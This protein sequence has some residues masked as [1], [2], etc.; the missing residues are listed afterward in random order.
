MCRAL[1]D[2]LAP[3]RPT[4]SVGPMAVPQ[5]ATFLR[6]YR[7]E[8]ELYAIEQAL[9]EWLWVE[10]QER[11][12]LADDEEADRAARVQGLRRA[13]DAAYRATPAA[14][15]FAALQR[16][17]QREQEHFAAEYRESLAE[18]ADPHP[19]VKQAQAHREVRE[20]VCGPATAPAARPAPEAPPPAPPA[21]PPPGARAGAGGAAGAAEGA[22]EDMQF[23]GMLMPLRAEADG[24]SM[25]A[26]A[27]SR[28]SPSRP[29]TV[30][31]DCCTVP[32]RAG[33]PGAPPSRDGTPSVAPGHGRDARRNEGRGLTPQVAVTNWCC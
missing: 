15:E 9:E 3:P 18:D 10:E 4:C 7:E 16:T 1:C 11:A 31:S 21:G 27:G 2:L 26:E 20:Q 19:M 14:Q 17:L 33:T 5:V 22:A 12:C 24:L 13:L 29:L 23:L 25:L 8:E 32:S 6:E 28:M 30:A